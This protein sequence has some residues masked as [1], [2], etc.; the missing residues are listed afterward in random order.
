MYSVYMHTN[1]INGKKYVGITSQKP[2]KRWNNGNGYIHQPFYKEINKYGWDGFYHEVLFDGLT[3]EE[4]KN[5]ES[6]LIEIYK[7]SSEKYG[8]NCTIGELEGMRKGNNN[9]FYGKKHTEKYK[10]RMSEL[11]KGK[12][13]SYETRKR[14]SRNRKGKCVGKDNVNARKVI[15]LDTGKKYN[16]LKEASIDTGAN[17]FKI[18]DVCRG[19][20]NKAGGLRWAYA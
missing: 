16:T 14:M 6:E 9:P 11:A 19:K 20:R 8:Y 7:T 1:K 15:C 4:A 10:A 12:V 17:Q 2:E 18:S 3:E 13:F 5:K